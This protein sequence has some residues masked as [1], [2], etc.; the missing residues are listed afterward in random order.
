[1]KIRKNYLR[2]LVMEL[3][4]APFDKFAFADQRKGEVPEEKNNDEEQRLY[5]DIASYFSENSTISKEDAE[6]IHD[7]LKSGM[8][9]DVF[10]APKEQTV[11]RGMAVD[12]N[13]MR[14][15]L[16][17]PENAEISTDPGDSDAHFTFTPRG[18][19]G[20]TSWTVD[21]EVAKKFADD[22]CDRKRTPFQLIMIAAT[23]DNTNRLAAGPD[24]LY[25]IPGFDKYD[26]ESEVIGLGQ[27]K[28]SKI[29]WA[30]YG[31]EI[32]KPSDELD[33]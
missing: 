20:A 9:K 8:Y 13:F 6:L 12:G 14:K 23:D 24:G 29:L 7:I 18:D 1:M 2:S 32:E 4:N 15:A 11:Y 19:M 10:H 16:K 5:D 21:F 28:V 25:K 30:Y 26:I 31:S 22:M 3:S 33:W 27:I 17:L